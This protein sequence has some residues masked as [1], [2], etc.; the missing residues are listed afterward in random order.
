M[1]Y[2]IFYATTLPARAYTDDD[3]IAVD[4]SQPDEHVYLE[5]LTA[6]LAPAYTTAILQHH[7]GVLTKDGDPDRV[8]SIDL[9]GKFILIRLIDG[10]SSK[11]FVFTCQAADDDIL[12]AYT[13]RFALENKPGTNHYTCYDLSWFLG[14]QYLDRALTVNG[15]IAVPMHF[16]LAARDRD[17]AIVSNRSEERDPDE[18]GGSHKFARPDDDTQPWSAFD[19]IEYAVRLANDIL[20]LDI[21]MDGNSDLRNITDAFKGEG[22][23]RDILTRVISADRGYHWHMDAYTIRIDTYSDVAITD[24][25]PSPSVVCPAN[26]NIGTLGLTTDAR[27]GEVRVTHVENAHYSD[28]EVRGEN[29]RVMATFTGADVLQSDWEAADES[30]YNA[31]DPKELDRPEYEH[32]FRRFILPELWD[33]YRDNATTDNAWPDWTPTDPAQINDSAQQPLYLG[34]LVFDRTLPVKDEK[35]AFRKPFCL[36]KDDDGYFLVHKAGKDRKPTHLRLL[37][38]APGIYLEPPYPHLFAQGQYTGSSSDAP[39]YDWDHATKGLQLTVSYYTNEPVRVTLPTAEAPASG[40]SQTK[41]ITVPDHHYWWRA[42]NTVVGFDHDALIIEAAEATIRDDSPALL[43]IANL[44]AVWY[45]RRR[46]KLTVPY[47]KARLLDRLGHLINETVPTGGALTPAGTVVSRIAY[48]FGDDSITAQLQTDFRDMDFAS[49]ASPRSRSSRAPRAPGGRIGADPRNLQAIESSPAIGGS[50]G[51][52]DPI[53]VSYTLADPVEDSTWTVAVTNLRASAEVPP[54]LL[55]QEF[56]D[57]GAQITFPTVSWIFEKFGSGTVR[58]EIG[59]RPTSGGG[60]AEHH[61]SDAPVLTFIIDDDSIV[62]D[63]TTLAAKTQADGMFIR[64]ASIDLS[65]DGTWE[66]PNNIKTSHVNYRHYPAASRTHLEMVG[67]TL[68]VW[69]LGWR[70]AD[71][72]L[73]PTGSPDATTIAIPDEYDDYIYWGRKY[74]IAYPL[75]GLASE[76]Y[77]ADHDQIQI[78]HVKETSG[79]YE[80]TPFTERLH[81]GA[82]TALYIIEI[83]ANVADNRYTVDA[84]QLNHGYFTNPSA[85]QT[86]RS[87]DIEDADAYAVQIYS[88]SDLVGEHYI[89]ALTGR[90]HFVF[91]P[92]ILRNI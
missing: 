46:A 58:L 69:N 9:L 38:D 52:V 53:A 42:P 3:W 36:A 13:D 67:S 84:W 28:V 59:F 27:M 15:T 17:T 6:A 60:A 39:L 8:S 22:S 18:D 37:D 24:G 82:S 78:C 86:A 40:V 25:A 50:G 5:R 7:H 29:I 1:T 73:L 41:V 34:N 71:S 70:S 26:A 4:N 33:G 74:N 35:G 2:K 68:K 47:Q 44:A 54:G 66:I 80:I 81:I 32:V 62:S 49:V 64:L 83:T 45:G 75:L 21:T 85:N 55:G 92:E 77:W 87:P 10:A 76:A 61:T 65:E 23:I 16:N 63:P 88:G 11:D 12:G 57:P 43:R 30:A 31:A 20:A 90:G 19:V 48:S 56:T 89:A 51:E 79:V 91:Q 14:R 72:K